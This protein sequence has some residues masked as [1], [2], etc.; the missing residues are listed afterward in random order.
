MRSEDHV[1]SIMGLNLLGRRLAV[2]TSAP[3][4][5]GQ[6]SKEDWNQPDSIDEEKAKAG[7]DKMVEEGIIYGGAFSSLHLVEIVH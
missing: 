2:L 3:M 5:F 4:E 6:V 1:A 7:R